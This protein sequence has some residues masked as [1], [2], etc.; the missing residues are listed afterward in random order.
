MGRMRFELLYTKATNTHLQYLTRI[1]RPLQ[2]WL[3]E[4]AIVLRYICSACLVRQCPVAVLARVTR[5]RGVL[6]ILS[7]WEELVL[8][9]L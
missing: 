9:E 7:S 1:A 5:A 3:G 8:I 2:Q 6:C 4:S